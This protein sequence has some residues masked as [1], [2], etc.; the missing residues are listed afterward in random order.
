M[1]F[2]IKQNILRMFTMKNSTVISIFVIA[3]MLTPALGFSQWQEGQVSANFSLPAIAL[4]DIEPGGDNSLYFALTPSSESGDPV[5]VESTS[6]KKLWLN[7]SSSLASSQSSRK[8]IAEISQ[9]T[10]PEGVS[11]YI[12]AS[13][14]NGIGRGQLGQTA[15][16]VEITTQPA[17]IITNI[18]NC[19]TGDGINNGHLIKFSIGI[20]DYSKIESSG[21]LNFIVLYTITDN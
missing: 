7:Y 13:G 1:K 17:Q 5:I 19:F 15:G 20:S 9:G 12:E 2:K 14:Y 18:G 21:E 3:F 4:V 8:I 6:E 11:F 10:S 16:K